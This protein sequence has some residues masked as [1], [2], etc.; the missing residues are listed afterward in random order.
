MAH[1]Q[2]D[3]VYCSAAPVDSRVPESADSAFL[4]PDWRHQLGVNEKIVFPPPAAVPTTGDSAA[5]RMMK[6]GLK[7][8]QPDAVGAAKRNARNMR[9][10]FPCVLGEDD[11]A[12]WHSDSDGGPPGS[13][14]DDIGEEPGPAIVDPAPPAAPQVPDPAL[15]QNQQI[16]WGPFPWSLS[17]LMTGG[18]FSGWGANC[19][20]HHNH[21]DAVRCTK[22]FLFSTN[23]E[24]ETRCIA[25]KWLLMGVE[26]PKWDPDGRQQHVIDIRRNQI[27]LVD[28]D[29]L[30]AAAD[31][32][33]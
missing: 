8:V 12:E 23:T 4:V 7:S 11:A 3:A 10:R 2:V 14:E 16:P 22:S 24:A 15:P 6:Q 29:V 25:K 32:L 26:I 17:K 5:A 28:E 27:P 30:D 1:K 20:C 31:A 9:V 18:V 21:G 33:L 19:L 13:A